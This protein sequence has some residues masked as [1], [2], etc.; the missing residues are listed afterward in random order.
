MLTSIVKGK[1]ES[2]GCTNLYQATSQLLGTLLKCSGH[3]IAFFHY[4][5]S[6]KIFLVYSVSGF[7]ALI[8]SSE[9]G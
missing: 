5:T 9:E 6:L 3:F 1:V 2:T 8:I 4:L 7:W